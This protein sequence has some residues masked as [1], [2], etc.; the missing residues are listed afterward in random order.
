MTTSLPDSEA[1]FRALE[2]RLR[3]RRLQA[4]DVRAR[5]VILAFALL[6]SAFAFWRVRV[7]LDGLCRAHGA[8]TGA[9][10][11]AAVLA[12]IAVLGASLA[13]SRQGVMAAR[14]PG[15][16]W[17]TLPLAPARVARHMLSESRLPAF[18]VLPPALAAIVA[19]IGLLPL[20]W[21]A[22][23]AAAFLVAWFEGTR[24]AAALARHAAAARIRTPQP[25]PAATRLLLAVRAE[26]REASRRPP[27]W[28]RE[29]AWRAIAR[30]DVRATFQRAGTRARALA[31]AAFLALG[32]LMW[33][34]ATVPLQ[35]QAL[36]FAG[37]LPACAALGAWAIARTCGDPASAF[38]SL[39]LGV[40]DF[41]RARFTIM[42]TVLLVAIAVNAALAVSLPMGA[43]LALFVTWWLP[44]MGIATL[45]LHYALTLHPRANAAEYL[46]FGWLG[47]GLGASIMIPFL[48]WGVLLGGL[49][50]SAA[51]L[52]RWQTPEVE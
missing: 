23:L 21:L 32:A 46:Y 9:G 42:A 47:V 11:L 12:G 37:L 10:M 31:V 19:G 33:F 7:P 28:R 16:E 6:V 40:S 4:L 14:P 1:A 3:A 5:L 34:T 25:L 30:L 13:A 35:Q 22:L 45:G 52:H 29:A 51:R 44:G 18:A 2:A 38:R 27:R 36:A 41:W 17:L 43:R 48:G 8:L 20:P 26:T 49:L 39:P 15:P 24:L 50:H